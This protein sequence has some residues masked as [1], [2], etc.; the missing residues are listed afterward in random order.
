MVVLPNMNLAQT[1][2][3]TFEMHQ[4]K[5]MMVEHNVMDNSPSHV[6]KGIVFY[7]SKVEVNLAK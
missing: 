4:N 1:V 3:M 7:L 2:I 6:L 5:K